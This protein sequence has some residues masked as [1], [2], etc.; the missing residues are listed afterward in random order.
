MLGNRVQDLEAKEEI[1]AQSICQL[2]KK[3]S[4]HDRMVETLSMQLDDHVNRNRENN[5]GPLYGLALVVVEGYPE[6]SKIPSIDGS[7]VG[8]ISHA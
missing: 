1:N 2:V 5:N 7:C 6:S 4:E 3:V 8:G